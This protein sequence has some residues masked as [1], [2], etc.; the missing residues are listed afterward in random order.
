MVYR[1]S[2]IYYIGSTIVYRGSTIYY[3][4]STIVYRGSTIYYIGLTI[5]DILSPKNHR[6]STIE[7]VSEFYFLFFITILPF[8]CE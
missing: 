7:G 8:L 5:V 4:G 2:T 3:I 1:G 6:N